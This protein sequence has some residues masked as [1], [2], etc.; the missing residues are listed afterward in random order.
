M[1]GCITVLS[2]PCLVFLQYFH[3]PDSSTFSI[4]PGG[5]QPAVRSSSLPCWDL[6]PDLGQPALDA[7]LLQKQV[8]LAF[9]PTAVADSSQCWSLPA[10]VRQEFPRQSV[11]VPLENYRENGF[12]TRYFTFLWMPFFASSMCWERQENSWQCS[13]CVNLTFAFTFHGFCI[14]HTAGQM[15]E[16]HM[17]FPSELLMRFFPYAAFIRGKWCSYHRV[18]TVY[19]NEKMLLWLPSLCQVIRNKG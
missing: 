3:V 2:P 17:G 6:M 13:P 15:W 10:L 9:S 4:S 16:S 7:S 5:Q 19:H 8:L 1:S 14:L 18:A 11:A 12:C